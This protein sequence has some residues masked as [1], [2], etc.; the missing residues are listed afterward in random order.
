MRAYFIKPAAQVVA[1]LRCY[2]IAKLVFVTI[3]SCMK[4]RRRRGLSSADTAH[5]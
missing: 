4:N 2:E 3:P 1:K 5:S